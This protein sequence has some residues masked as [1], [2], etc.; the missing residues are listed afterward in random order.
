MIVYNKNLISHIE[1]FKT[2]NDL[3][4]TYNEKK[5]AIIIFHAKIEFVNPFFLILLLQYQK[6]R[7]KFLILD[8]L[9]CS[10]NIEGYIFTFLTQQIQ[11]N[12]IKYPSTII[13]YRTSNLER[14][15]KYKEI[16][17]LLR[18]E[19]PTTYLYMTEK[20]KKQN[21]AYKFCSEEY[22]FLPVLSLTN[23]TKYSIEYN[24]SR[25]EDNTSK[26]CREFYKSISV[27]YFSGNEYEKNLKL[28]IGQVVKSIKKP[29]YHNSGKL[30]EKEFSH[31]IQELNEDLSSIFFEL[32]D[33]IK[34]HT[35]QKEEKKYANA[36]LSSRF[37]KHDA[38]YEYIISDDYAKGFIESFKLTLEK[39]KKTIPPIMFSNIEDSYTDI[40]RKIDLKSTE[41]D[42]AVLEGI[43]GIKDTIG[44]REIQRVTIHFG[45]P[46]LLKLIQSVH[47]K[48]DIY[49]HHDENYYHI[50]Y[51]G[52]LNITPT[53]NLL[54]DNEDEAI[55]GAKG[56]HIYFTLPNT[57]LLNYV[58]KENLEN[59]KQPI[60]IK[61]QT[62]KNI[63]NKITYLKKEIDSFQYIP[64][65]DL[66]NQLFV[67]KDM[68]QIII[69]FSPNK[70]NE[71]YFNGTISD[72]LR[73]LFAYAFFHNTVDIYIYNFPIDEYKTYLSIIVEKLYD[74]TEVDIDIPNIIFQ[75]SNSFDITFIGG[76]TFDEL[77]AINKSI[78]IEYNSNKQSIFSRNVEDIEPKIHK[79]SKLFFQLGSENIILP[80][81]LIQNKYLDENILGLIIVNLLE[82]NSLNIHVDT[83][84]GY[85][86]NKFYQFKNLFSDSQW[87]NRLAFVLAQ[88]GNEYTYFLGTDKYTSLTIAVANS[89]LGSN[90]YLVVENILNK[91]D[92]KSIKEFIKKVQYE[93]CISPCIKALPTDY[94]KVI[95][96][97]KSHSLN[98][99]MVF[100][101]VTFLYDNISKYILNCLK[102]RKYDTSTVIDINLEEQ[103]SKSP[104]F[105]ISILRL[106]KDKDYFDV[107]NEECKICTCYTESKPLNEKPLYE[108]DTMNTFSLKNFYKS[109]Y[110][111]AP[112][113]ESVSIDSVLWH[114]SIHFVH[115]KRGHNHYTFYT[116]TIS[117][118]NQNKKDIKFCLKHKIKDDIIKL[119]NDRK[120]II[121][122]PRHATN[123]NFITYVDEYLF[124]NNATVYRFDK[125]S[126]EQNFYDIDFLDDD[127]SDATKTAIFFVDDE[128]SSGYTME[129]FYTLLRVK[130]EN[131]RFDAAIFMIDRTTINDTKVICN[132]I[133]GRN[134]EERIKHFYSFTKLEIK[135]IKTEI[136]NCFL[137]DKQKEYQD[138]LINCTLDMNRL[139]IAERIVKLNQTDAH[140]ID[141]LSSKTDL[142][143][144]L[145]TYLK[146][147]A[148]DYVYRNFE[149]FHKMVEKHFDDKKD[150]CDIASLH[151]D[152][153]NEEKSLYNEVKVYLKKYFYPFDNKVIEEIFVRICRYEISI[154][155]LKAISF[156]KLAYYEDIR[157]IATKIII[158]RLRLKIRANQETDTTLS[159][160]TSLQPFMPSDVS[161]ITIFS[162][163]YN[164]E[165]Y[166]YL[167]DN[168]SNHELI[169]FF[170]KY[171]NKSNLNYI[172]FLYITASYLD[173][174]YILAKENILFY[175]Q[176]SNYVKTY[177][178]PHELLH[179][180]PTA[181]KLITS[182][183]T[184]KARYFDQQLT[185][186]YCKVLD[187]VK[188]KSHPNFVHGTKR[189][190]LVNALFLENTIN[191]NLN[192]IINS[193]LSLNDQLL[194]LAREIEK[195]SKSKFKEYF[196]NEQ[197]IQCDNPRPL[198]Q[199]SAEFKIEKIY[200][201][202]YMD[203]NYNEYIKYLEESKLLNLLSEMKELK[204]NDIIYPLYLGAVSDKTN[205]KTNLKYILEGIV[206]DEQKELI[207]KDK[208]DCTWSNMWLHSYEIDND[209][210]KCTIIRLVEIDYTKLK[211]LSNKDEIKE[212]KNLW[213][214]PVGLI[215]ASHGGDYTTHLVYSRILLSLQQYLIDFFRKKFD[216]GK[217]Q[218]QIQNK[219]IQ[220]SHDK[221][222][223][224]LEKVS[225]TYGK[226]IKIAHHIV[227]LEN[228]QEK[229]RRKFSYQDILEMV[230][231]YTRGLEYVF[232]IGSLVS[233]KTI[234]SLD[235]I[236]LSSDFIKTIEGF[237][238]VAP[239]FKEKNPN[240]DT[241]EKA[242]K[243]KYAL[244]YEKDIESIF[245]YFQNKEEDLKAIIFELIFN[246]IRSN[247]D[248]DSLELKLCLS[249]QYISIQNNG[250][251]IS[252]IKKIFT[253]HYSDNEGSGI[254]LYNI[255][256]Y[257]ENSRMIIEAKNLEN[258]K[259]NVEF[260]VRRK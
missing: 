57:G 128:I 201:N 71:N 187:G 167:R 107:E 7:K 194:N 124:D 110:K 116:K 59:I 74:A 72:F 10:E 37:N 220:E 250:K 40:E 28:A 185:E 75:N 254:G 112:N 122:A 259:F 46:M 237:L 152:Y 34:R 106:K 2:I 94:S 38:Q 208:I 258:N 149:N 96:D 153:S 132:Y 241:V 33:N 159:D 202:E 66:E 191:N 105:P 73:A 44:L 165:E 253:K 65:L 95:F 209:E 146:M 221:L 204:Q 77:L 181:V 179:I 12:A 18:S 246:A 104:S 81:A 145:K 82:K 99:I 101:S 23:E 80:F 109:P 89:F 22:T 140:T 255:K 76:E 184:D 3:K 163:M 207:L 242:L 257:L 45:I 245:L 219:Y 19:E 13:D 171:K 139:Q 222:Q 56:T 67:Q 17:T 192:L 55:R 240:N 41:N 213:I 160:C 88:Q 177:D 121:F 36:F 231:K 100:S 168:L 224:I 54:K 157:K 188:T 226:Y 196:E 251:P 223:E 90:E 39:N 113:K 230:K 211:Q 169:D 138:K 133:E 164:E 234:N 193:K 127:I 86:L 150:R 189:Y 115:A 216:Y 166:T 118:F 158:C 31:R 197:K 84:K 182:K 156:P 49:V 52:S 24:E 9:D 239:V 35:E 142:R 170:T 64:I 134:Y 232:E 26:E 70:D 98:N 252:N 30:T 144:K 117:F 155:L 125:E 119:L 235:E 6:Q 198:T 260:I 249:E 244:S 48:L 195:Y 151:S 83:K 131:R 148:V 229:G 85:H 114:D 69:K 11:F 102:R 178:Y 210:K 42:Q 8:T 93:S 51:D 154:A 215:V 199:Y 1:I 68:H 143:T 14:N 16:Y 50:V 172:N 126:G 123:N 141:S 5:Y 205:D 256:D 62:F 212:N 206:D 176:I 238:E 129:Y 4:D 78:A 200:I 161:K 43:F 58:E 183:Y 147:Y 32:I 92:Q 97:R 61:N 228:Y 225:H 135:P 227:A 29:N 180:Y 173:I 174:S 137:C 103:K 47:G 186:F 20:I 130:G 60:N 91:D 79:S 25:F 111:L 108:L 120:V 27:D 175:Y 63:F 15:K 21:Y 162:T 248:M 236:S 247:Q 190:S 53:V 243:A 217:F 203:R 233:V 214:K 218:E 87:V 136:E